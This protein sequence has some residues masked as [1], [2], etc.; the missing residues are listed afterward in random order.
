MHMPEI[1]RIDKHRRVPKA[2]KKA[3]KTKAVQRESAKR[4]I[5]NSIKAGAKNLA[6]PV[7]RKKHV[8][9]TQQ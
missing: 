6:R 8:V 2:I 3:Q 1:S 7:E 5:E 4:K 9:T